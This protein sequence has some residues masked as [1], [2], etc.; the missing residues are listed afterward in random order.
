MQAIAADARIIENHNAVLRKLEAELIAVAVGLIAGLIT[1]LVLKGQLKSV[2]R[3]NEANLYMKKESL[4]L[5]Q[6]GDYFM[7]RNLVRTERPKNNGS[8]GSSGSFRSGGSG[9]IGGGGKF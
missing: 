8:S 9:R 2:K 4:A 1:A 6:S 7:Y 5:T 3:Q